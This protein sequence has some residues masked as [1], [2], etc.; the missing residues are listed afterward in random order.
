MNILVAGGTGLIGKP[1]VHALLTE[2]QMTVLSRDR[3]SIEKH[4]NQSVSA[5]TWSQLSALDARQFDAVINLCGHNIAASRWTDSVKQLII[6]SRVKTNKTLINWLIQ[7]HCQ[8]HYYCANA[9]GVY[10]LQ[11]NGDPR[12]LDEDSTIDFEHP[13]DFL[14]EVGVRWQQSLQPAIDHGMS[15]TITRF[16]VILKRGEGM[17]KKLEPSFQFGLGSTIGDGQQVI[18]WIHIDD[19]VRAY[20]FLLARPTLT[21]AINLTS[22]NPVHQAQFAQIFAETLNRP[23]ILKTPAFVIRLLFGEMGEMLINRGQRVIPKRLPEAGFE[24][25]F[26]DLAAALKHEFSG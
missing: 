4:F 20:Q 10:G 1:L 8:P 9:I 6:D 15:V 18:S 23:L 5:Y 7:S 2:H 12:A 21:G 16:G 17:L 3:Q 25:A 11:D 14:S 24:F 26:S 22:P 19:V 13:K